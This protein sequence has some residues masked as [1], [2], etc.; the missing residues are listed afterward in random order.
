MDSNDLESEHEITFWSFN[1]SIHCNVYFFV[2][3]CHKCQHVKGYTNISCDVLLSTDPFHFR[4]IIENPIH[5]VW[6]SLIHIGVNVLCNVCNSSLNNLNKKLRF[7]EYE[8]Q[9]GLM[10]GG[11]QDGV[12][13]VGAIEIKFLCFKFISSAALSPLHAKHS[14]LQ[15]CLSIHGRSTLKN[16]PGDLPSRLQFNSTLSAPWDYRIFSLI[17]F[18][19]VCNI[20]PI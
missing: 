18:P 4:I 10:G 11:G 12:T 13:I 2:I 19:N 5:P 14:P 17:F 3:H 1:S 16:V 6:G 15:L 20:D 9:W 8:S 7:L